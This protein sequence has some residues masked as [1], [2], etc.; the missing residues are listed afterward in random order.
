M[1]P[2]RPKFYCLEMYPYPSGALHI[3][4]TRVYSIGDLIARFKRMNGYQVLHPMGW[5]SFGMPAENYAIEHGIH[6]AVSTYASIDPSR[7]QMRRMGYSYDWRREEACS[8]PGYYKWTQWRFLLLYEKGL[9]YRRK[10]PVNWCRRCQTVLAYE[11]VE[12]GRC[13]RCESDVQ[14]RD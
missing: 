2:G 7:A 3:G 4:H 14:M 5:D 13:W 10:A 12:E 9:A 1:D 8:H 6:P 11:Q